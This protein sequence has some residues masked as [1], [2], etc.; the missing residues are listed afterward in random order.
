VVIKF[1]FILIFTL[2]I[3]FLLRVSLSS[4][5]LSYHPN[6]YVPAN[7]MLTPAHILPEWSSFPFYAIL[8][9]IPDELKGV[10]SI[11]GAIVLLLFLP[12]INTS[13]VR[14]SIFRPIYRK[15]F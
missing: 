1:L 8:R 11:G 3:Y 12:F 6:N 9:S 10:A 15:L 2:K 14:S 4:F 13:K 7:P 5:L